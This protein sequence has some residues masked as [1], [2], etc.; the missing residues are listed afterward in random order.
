MF[1]VIFIL[2]LLLLTSCAPDKQRVGDVVKGAPLVVVTIN[3]PTTYYED[4][5][6]K[7]T[8]FEFDLATAFAYDIGVDVQFLTVATAAQAEEVLRKGH[9]HIAAAGYITR[10][11][12]AKAEKPRD[13]ILLGPAFHRAENILVYRKS[14]GSPEKLDRMTEVKIAVIADSDADRTVSS[15]EGRDQ[16]AQDGFQLIR[17]QSGAD[18]EALLKQVS[19]GETDYAIID[20]TS[21]EA[22]KQFF[23]QLEK[24]YGVGFPYRYAW[25]Y[26]E[27]SRDFLLRN[28][29][30][31]FAKLGQS[32]LLKRLLEKHFGFTHRL[33]A[34]DLAAFIE[35]T[36]STLPRY[37]D[38]FV[39][40]GEL[41][42][43]DWRLLAAIGYQESHWNPL[44][45]SFTGV[46]G[47]MML[48]ND[49]ADRMKVKD[50]TDA[51]ESIFGGAKYL[52]L[53]RDAL[54]LRIAE[55]DR[56]M[57]ALAAYNQGQGHLEAAR[58]L[59]Q[60]NNANA[61]RWDNVA[62][63]LPKLADPS[64]YVTLKT[65]YARGGEAVQFA[66]NVRSYFDTLVKI[67]N[68]KSAQMGSLVS[69]QSADSPQKTFP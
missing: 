58:I 8:G 9:A 11:K 3:G 49:T 40:A 21:F 60:R 7:P 18:G 15:H 37:R 33:N 10:E 44:A 1:R 63:E 24:A 13:G 31:F 57:F 64:V 46:R 6:G 42:K 66:T 69:E 4:A 68:R 32:G 28:S 34:I 16:T 50:R 27:I 39:E 5:Q 53:I 56:T 2:L 36:Q 47:M 67:E 48:T 22:N 35:K 17:L 41:T 23:P 26:G 43:I 62:K 25:Q 65:G 14:Q 19:S 38:M 12:T 59:T 54:P 30:T 20:S 61:D 45:V 55:P 52:A 51:R 29:E